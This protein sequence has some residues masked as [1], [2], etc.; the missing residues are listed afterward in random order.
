M[1]YS[2]TGIVTES[3]DDFVIVEA[4]G[5]GYQVF[6]PEPALRTLQRDQEIKLYTYH[7]IREDQQTLFGFTTIEDRQLFTILTSVS[8]VGPKVA[9]KT[10]SA[11]QTDAIIQAILKENIVALTSVPGIGKRVAERLIVELKDKL[12][13]LYA[14]KDYSK[15]AVSSAAV[16]AGQI[17]DDVR[18]ALKTLGYS[19]EEIKKAVIRASEALT[20]S[21]SLEDS[22]KV[23]LKHL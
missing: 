11:L 12:P 5:V 19:N 13:K 23:L 1:I 4:C 18:I 20:P 10:M 15:M 6:V 17:N 8:G 22:V 21:L 14:A 9:L 3:S 7:H 16:A 2:V